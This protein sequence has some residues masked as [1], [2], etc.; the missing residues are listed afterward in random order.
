LLDVRATGDFRD[1]KIGRKIRDNEL[2]HIPYLLIVGEKEAESGTVAVRRQ[3][4][5]DMGAMNVEDF[6]KM[7]NAE[8][9]AMTEEF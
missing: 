8:V 6:A 4:E 1:E 3:G 7:L 2:K 5:G 9:K